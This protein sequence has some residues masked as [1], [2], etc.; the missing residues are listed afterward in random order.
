MVDRESIPQRR[1]GSRRAFLTLGASSSTMVLLGNRPVHAWECEPSPPAYLVRG[2][3]QDELTE[4]LNI[5]S[6]PTIQQYLLDLDPDFQELASLPV[7]TAPPFVQPS[8]SEDERAAI[9]A[10][11]EKV[12][13][14]LVQELPS[15]QRP[16]AQEIEAI[17][18]AAG[19]N[20][21]GFLQSGER[22]VTNLNTFVLP[23]N[24][25]A[26][27]RLSVVGDTFALADATGTNLL[28]ASPLCQVNQNPQN[29]SNDKA[30]ILAGLILAVIAFV[31]SLASIPVPST[32][33]DKIA[34]A[35]TRLLQ[36][37]GFRAI[38]KGLIEVL[39]REGATLKEKLAA[40]FGFLKTLWNAG[41]LKD[42]LK[43]IFSGLGF[44]DL[45]ITIASIAA[46]F[47]TGGAAVLAKA[48]LAIA[49]LIVAAIP[50]ATAYAKSQQT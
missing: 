29:K 45:A 42:I 6:D 39:K 3:L 14:D 23:A 47:L 25:A 38:F 5:V 21:F 34:P 35:A 40:I 17:K 27:P 1:I 18:G 48:A 2:P 13:N 10:T 33:A 20:V 19:A 50:L 15:N 12:V 26:F 28:I 24:F 43:T 49:T 37:P 9:K 22:E 4:L 7:P 16:N 41:A 36:T 44:I 31:G 46:I 30:L 11:I 8:I 32:G